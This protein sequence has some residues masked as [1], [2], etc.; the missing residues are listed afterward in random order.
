MFEWQNLKTDSNSPNPYSKTDKWPAS[1]KNLPNLKILVNTVKWLKI[2]THNRIVNDLT[3]VKIVA[4]F[5]KTFQ[6][7]L[8]T[9][10]PIQLNWTKTTNMHWCIA[11]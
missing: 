9:E 4:V 1:L 8:T 10:R 11:L 6:F 7:L 5:S 3:V 2:W